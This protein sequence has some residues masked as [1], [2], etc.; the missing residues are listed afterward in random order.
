LGIMK[1]LNLTFLFFRPPKLNDP[2]YGMGR[3]AH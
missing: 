2:E 1:T 3:Y